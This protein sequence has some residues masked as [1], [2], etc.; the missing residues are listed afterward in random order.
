MFHVKR[1]KSRRKYCKL[2]FLEK[3]RYCIVF[4]YISEN[5]DIISKRVEKLAK[6]IYNI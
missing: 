3:C 5:T 1:S 4:E 2:K 6:M